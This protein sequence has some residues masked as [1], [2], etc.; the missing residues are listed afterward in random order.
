M[1][2]HRSQLT[3]ERSWNHRPSMLRDYRGAPGSEDQM[4]ATC[5]SRSVMVGREPGDDQQLFGVIEARLLICSRFSR[6]KLEKKSSGAPMVETNKTED[7]KRASRMYVVEAHSMIVLQNRQ[8]AS[9]FQMRSA[10]FLTLVL[11]SVISQ[12][13]GPWVNMRLALKSPS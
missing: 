9:S 8:T 4:T 10:P 1:A 5:A 3:I 6:F 12:N 11:R 13:V 7:E 2:R